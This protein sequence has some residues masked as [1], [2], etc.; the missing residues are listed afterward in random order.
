M[1]KIVVKAPTA[2]HAGGSGS[3]CITGGLGDLGRLAA[4]WLARQGA[5]AVTLLGRSGKLPAHLAAAL[6][7]FQQ[8]AHAAMVT[9]V[10]ANVA[11]QVCQA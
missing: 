6:L 2:V 1:G 4:A 3:V 7:G 9:T 10:M 11:C 5:P 8:D